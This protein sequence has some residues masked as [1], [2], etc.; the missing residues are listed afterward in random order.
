MKEE[1]TVVVVVVIADEDTPGRGCCRAKPPT[2]KEELEVEEIAAVDKDTVGETPEE[3]KG[4][5]ELPRLVE[6]GTIV[7]TNTA[8]LSL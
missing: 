4:T 7:V 6:L 1:E 8:H 2:P 5:L 3:K